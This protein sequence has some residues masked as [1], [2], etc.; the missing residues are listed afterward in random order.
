MILVS[1]K[2]NL[3][4]EY[5]EYNSES[6]LSRLSKFA[7]LRFNY[8]KGLVILQALGYIMIGI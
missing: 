4:I 5:R 2:P 8:R 6:I 7:T 1:V 3:G